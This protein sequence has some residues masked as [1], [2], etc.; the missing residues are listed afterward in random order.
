VTIDD[1]LPVWQW[2]SAHTTRVAARPER[3]LAVL[4][5][6]SARDLPLSGL[7]M[8]VAL[9]ARRFGRLELLATVRRRA[10]AAA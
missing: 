3:A 7:L 4:R 5:E 6:I 8:R 10:E 1:L 2:R 9:A